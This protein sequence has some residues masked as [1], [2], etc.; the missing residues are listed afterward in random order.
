MTEIRQL[1]ED[2]LQAVA[3]EGCQDAHCAT[4]S[5][6]RSALAPILAIPAVEE[7]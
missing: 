4:P 3:T 2:V 7:V 1:V 5:E 6:L